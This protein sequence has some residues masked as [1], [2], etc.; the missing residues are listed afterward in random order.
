M[1]ERTI[2]ACFNSDGIITDHVAYEDQKY[3][4]TP[5]ARWA[6]CAIIEKD[7]I[8][9][10]RIHAAKI[11]NGYKDNVR[12]RVCDTAIPYHVKELLNLLA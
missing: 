2:Y 10:L 5:D 8:A 1:N 11:Q 7:D 6:E 4:L 9:K 3:E 12:I